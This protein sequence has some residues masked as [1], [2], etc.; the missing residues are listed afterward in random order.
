MCS[1]CRNFSASA[2][3]SLRGRSDSAAVSTL[4][5]AGVPDKA[6]GCGGGGGGVLGVSRLCGRLRS[7]AAGTILL[8]SRL[9]RLLLLPRPSRALFSRRRLDDEGMLGLGALSACHPTPRP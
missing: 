5:L 9:T 7:D 1:S 2:R 8:G 6:V 3:R 4:P